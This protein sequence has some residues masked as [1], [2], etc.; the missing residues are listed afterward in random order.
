MKVRIP[1]VYALQEKVEKSWIRQLARPEE[2]IDAEVVR[3]VMDGAEGFEVTSSSFPIP[4]RILKST[5]GQLPARDEAAVLRYSAATVVNDVLDA[6]AGIWLEHPSLPSGNGTSAT[7]NA[8]AAI[9]SWRGAFAYVQEDRSTGVIGLRP[10]QAG[11][12]HAI[13][14]HWS[15]SNDVASVVLP[16]GTGKTE[17]MLGVLTSACCER[18]IVVVP[19]E[20]LRT[21]IANK[22]MTLGLL[23]AKGSTILSQTAHYPVVGI[24]EHRIESL[25]VFT[26]YFETCNV[27]V[28]TSHIAGQLP[29]EFQAR[30]AEL[31][32]H[33]FIDEAHHAEAPTWKRFK[34]KF[35]SRR[36]L[37][38][39]ATPFRDDDQP[40]DGKIIYRYPL[41]Q[42]QRDGYFR[43]I[44]FRS[45]FEFNENKAD[46]AIAKATI[47][48]LD[49]DKTGLHVAMARA[50]DIPRATQVFEIYKAIGRYNPI[51]LHSRLKPAERREALG[52]LMSGQSRLVVC[53]DMLGEGFDMP[54]LKIAAFH[55]TRK[56][57]PVTLQLAG[58]FTR[59]REDLGNATFIA[60]VA[61]P[62]VRQELEKLYSQD[63]DWNELLPELSDTEIDNQIEA[64][65]FLEGF[66]PFSGEIPLQEIKPATSMVIYRTRCSVWKPKD[67]RKGLHGLT[68]SD[69]V[70]HTVNQKENM[71]VV[72]VGTSKPVPWTEIEAVQDWEWELL[73]AIWDK[74][75]ELLY[76]HG[77][78]KSGEYRTMAKA[79]CGEDV[80]LI[81]DPE[82]YRCF[83]GVKR[84]L[85]TNLGMNE[86]FGR[87]IRYIARMG[88]D[89][90]ARL[91]E[92]S[93]KTARRAVVSGIGFENGA[94][95]TI[96]ATK[97]GRVWSFQRLR[98]ESFAKWCQN[99]GAKVI[100]E[101]IDP[102]GVLKGTLIPKLVK[103]RPEVMPI[104]VEWPDCIFQ[105]HESAHSVQ[106]GNV[107]ATEFWYLGIELVNPA[108][109]GDILF[110]V[111]SDTSEIVLRL[112]LLPLDDDAISTYQFVPVNGAD[113]TLTKRQK[114]WPLC[115]YFF[116]TPPLITFADGSYLE[117][118]MLVALPDIYAPYDRQRI[119]DWD[120]SDVDMKKEA[121][122]VTREPDSI[123]YK[124]IEHLK[125]A[126]GYDIIYDDD[127]SG[128]SA[129]VVTIKVI[130]DNAR[131]TI[132][133]DFYHCKYSHDSSAGAR[134]GDLYEVC[135]QAQ[136]SISW[137]QNQLRH[138]ELFVHL[139]RRDPKIHKGVELSRYQTGDQD[140]LATIRNRSRVAEMKLRVFIVQPGLSRFKATP[141][142]LS[143]LSVTENFLLETYGV[144]FGV[145][146]SA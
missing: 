44:T 122:G 17:T 137:L 42:A 24:L 30:T 46:K 124:V 29:P 80:Q 68:A 20:A 63:P 142:Q 116:E 57:L 11:A 59:A 95:A 139:L 112:E 90:A 121:Q 26:T 28:T 118:N 72:V 4:I 75:R 123:Q 132:E 65:S 16:T 82:L 79:L 58:R 13:H 96:G 77:S 54:E 7:S 93:K 36:I 120:W 130:E 107:P 53:V 45:V 64:R 10:P 111:F 81:Q 98:L 73:V 1:G 14:A 110:R 127:G 33:L 92:S 47:D 41:R 105:D 15:V 22:F 94:T 60:N 113:G 39:T 3:F 61:N 84:L 129:D 52:T 31:C 37:Q 12:L 117:G 146:G 43:P 83:H 136:K 2:E 19:T 8:K 106:L 103:T 51:L 74:K 108:E 140:L 138:T 5:P 85:L 143:L 119:I 101:T 9:D 32:T 76:I 133:V 35:G 55:D 87:Q 27:I 40:I 18:V 21:Q 145:I 48:E 99:V 38:F 49:R 134:I 88:A 97:R 25:D 91:S 144:P 66:E 114:T 115:D 56:S 50:F 71:L 23:K 100:D 128:E 6:S 104:A 34:A 141:D 78:S 67:F 109:T 131:T 135:G 62:G 102:E 89:V 69:K 125:K 126:G 86:Q 70:S